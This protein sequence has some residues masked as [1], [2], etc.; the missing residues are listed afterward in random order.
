MNYDILNQDMGC[1]TPLSYNI[2]WKT[3]L[4]FSLTLVLLQIKSLEF[5]VNQPQL[6]STCEVRFSW[7]EVFSV[8]LKPVAVFI[9]KINN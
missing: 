6:V 1:E 8:S 9:D 2:I 7:K 5:Q 3:L 4:R